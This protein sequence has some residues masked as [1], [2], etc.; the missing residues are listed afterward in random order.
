[1][2]SERI[3]GR[4]GLQGSYNSRGV[5]NGHVTVAWPVMVNQYNR[6]KRVALKTK[7]FF[8]IGFFIIEL[9]L[10]RFAFL[11]DRPFHVLACFPHSAAHLFLLGL[12]LF[13]LGGP[14]KFVISSC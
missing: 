7:L 14:G 2:F 6:R 9:F 13:G 10:F 3:L 1:M 5:G 12:Y 11:R 8:E 4:V